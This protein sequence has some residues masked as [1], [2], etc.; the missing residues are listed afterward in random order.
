MIKGFVNKIKDTQ[1]IA[2]EKNVHNWY[3]CVFH[4]I[5]IILGISLVLSL[6]TIQYLGV[7]L[8][9]TL[10]DLIL[11]FQPAI[12]LPLIYS[13]TLS[14]LFLQK[15]IIL[16]ILA[17]E[18]LNKIIFKLW[19]KMDMYWFRK[20]RK[21]SPITEGLAKFQSKM[22][23]FNKSKSK[24]QK[25]LIV[26]GVITFLLIIQIGYRLPYEIEEPVLTPEEF[27]QTVEMTP[28]EYEEY[29]EMY[30]SIQQEKNRVRVNTGN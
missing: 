6:H 26:I 22:E 9:T 21:H 17:F 13:L 1:K 20:Y 24:K 12:F 11:T 14:Y 10:G 4:S 19:Q 23:K 16:H 18:Q 2:R 7:N 8:D 3:N 15:L 5:I 27:S 28:E 25:R 29:K 30:D